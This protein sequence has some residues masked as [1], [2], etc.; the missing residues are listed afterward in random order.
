MTSVFAASVVTDGKGSR[1]LAATPWASSA[2]HMSES[3]SITS[4]PPTWPAIHAAAWVR[5]DAATRAAASRAWL[6]RARTELDERAAV[7]EV[8]VS[9]MTVTAA[10]ARATARIPSRRPRAVKRWRRRNLLLPER[11]R[12]PMATRDH[13]RDT[14]KLTVVARTRPHDGSTGT[15][16]VPVT[17]AGSVAPVDLNTSRACLPSSGE[18]ARHRSRVVRYVT[19]RVGPQAT[20]HSDPA[21]PVPLPSPLGVRAIWDSRAHEPSPHQPKWWISPISNGTERSRGDRRRGIS[22]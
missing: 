22:Q 6:A 18:L 13:R 8:P 20:R 1:R 3:H 10:T 4:P 15:S 17:D 12:Q 9:W 21:R 11:P 5:T 14:H 19:T 7:E 2:A 16:A